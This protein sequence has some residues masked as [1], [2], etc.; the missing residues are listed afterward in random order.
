MAGRNA[1]T[2]CKKEIRAHV[3]GQCG[4]AVRKAMI[5]IAFVFA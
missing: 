1:A 4:E 2:A 5:A 3:I